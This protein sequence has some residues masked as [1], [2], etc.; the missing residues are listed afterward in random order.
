[1]LKQKQENKIKE[2]NIQLQKERTKKKNSFQKSFWNHCLVSNSTLLHNVCVWV[3][4]R[5]V[6][7]VYLCVRV[8]S[9]CISVEPSG[10]GSEYL[11]C[12]VGSGC[13]WLTAIQS[14]AQVFRLLLVGLLGL[15][16]RGPGRMTGVGLERA[17]VLSHLIRYKIVIV[18][19]VLRVV[20]SGAPDWGDVST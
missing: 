13:D 17:V 5:V 18:L 4:V 2:L 6:W 20:P 15:R 14:D 12:F 16:K 19:F 9:G 3:C 7:C 11:R 10:N 1:M 8:Q